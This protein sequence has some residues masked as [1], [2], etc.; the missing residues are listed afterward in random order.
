MHKCR[1]TREIVKMYR[2]KVDP[3]TWWE[4]RQQNDSQW[5]KKG[6]M[7]I[8]ENFLVRKQRK[9]RDKV[10]KKLERETRERKWREIVLRK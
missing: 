9:Y 1:K 2:E 7:E 4:S 5:R 6:E 10:E 8:I 3:E